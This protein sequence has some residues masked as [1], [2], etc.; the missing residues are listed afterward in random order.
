MIEWI[1]GA[2]LLAGGLLGSGRE[3]KAESWKSK[4]PSTDHS[5]YQIKLDAWRT[6]WEPIVDRTQWIPKSVASDIVARFPPP[7]RSI[8]KHPN[9]EKQFVESL[10]REFDQYNRAYIANQK[11]LLRD[12]FNTVEKNPLTDEQIDCC[13]CMDDAVQIVAAAGSGKTSTIVAKVGYALSAGLV[14][15]EQVLVL[16]FNRAVADELQSRISDRLGGFNNIDAVTVRTFNAFG[17]S[18]IANA[19]KRKPSLADWAQQGS[20]IEMILKIIH[21]LRLSNPKFR[22]DWD[23]FRIVYGRDIGH[24]ETPS[25]INPSIN[26]RPSILTANGDV[27]RSQEERMIAD[28]LFLYGI[29]YRYE[30]KYVYDT[31][32]EYHGQYRPD[33]Y[34]PDI[35]LYHEHFALNE[36]GLP[37]PHFEGDYLS[38]VSWKRELHKRM[39][40]RL[41]ETTS[42]EIRGEAGLEVLIS[43]LEQEGI[44][45]DFNPERPT[46]GMLP[47]TDKQL[48]NTVRVFQQHVK[49]NGLSHKKLREI[50]SSERSH[51]DRQMKFLSLYEQISDEWERRL[52]EE[53]CVDFD[54]MLLK[55]TEHIETNRFSSPYK[56]ILTDEF[57]DASQSKVKLLKAL[58][59][60]GGEK[61]HLCVVGDDYQGINRFAGADVSVMTQFENVF[62]HSTRLMLNTTFRC[63]AHLCD[64]S[65]K[66]IQANPRQIKKS[67]KTTNTYSKKSLL[68]YASESPELSLSRLEEDLRS[69]YGFVRSGVLKS[70]SSA[71][72]KVMLLG[73][74][75]KD[76]PAELSDWKSQFGS[77]LDIDFRTIHAA[78]GL[79]A[80]YVMLINVIE[81]SMGFPSQIT[82]DPLLQLA[83]PDPDAFPLAEERRL[84]YV[85]L[86]RARRQVRIYTEPNRPS[87]FLCELVKNGAVDIE[88]DSGSLSICPKCGKGTM[89]LQTSKFGLFEVCSLSPQCDYKKNLPNESTIPIGVKSSNRLTE[90]IDVG[91]VCPRCHSGTMVIRSSGPYRP[92]LACSNYPSC[93]TTAVIK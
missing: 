31:V 37:P 56:M 53:E 45:L 34:Y 47:V 48:A 28:R 20:D 44:K 74:Y 26:G 63:P 80:D 42:F 83:M 39:G 60:S 84:F 71:A 57:Q 68:A 62:D 5:D 78:K 36:N 70:D 66:F 19:T 40:T 25:A 32:T 55:A 6:K 90:K 16:A 38:G 65:S 50:A 81:D 17:L 29:N 51:P 27:V 11:E 85:A 30:Q 82:D 22:H 7:E 92:F 43:K 10:L 8:I 35:D 46:K 3:N 41:L 77:C 9:T 93:K 86:T 64:V 59:K 73:R 76:E 75:N 58:L 21:D 72:I 15:P 88:T 2:A 23:L 4:T 61:S 33:F 87:Q 24:M 52:Q 49:S 18:V 69:M 14:K 1:I 13:I 91:A 54:D 12:F 79:E 89:R 67:I